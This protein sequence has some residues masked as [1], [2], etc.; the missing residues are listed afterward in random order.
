MSALNGKQKE[1]AHAGVYASSVMFRQHL[2][3]RRQSP[4][5]IAATGRRVAVVLGTNADFPTR[6]VVSKQVLARK[7][8]ETVEKMPR[9]LQQMGAELRGRSAAEL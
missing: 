4:V 6:P 1:T 2:K 7:H 5:R 9:L 3:L 8:A